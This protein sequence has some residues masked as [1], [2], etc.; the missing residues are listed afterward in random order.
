ML[1]G[2]GDQKKNQQQN[3]QKTNPQPQKTPLH[4]NTS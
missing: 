1:L 3:P 4:Q 2:E